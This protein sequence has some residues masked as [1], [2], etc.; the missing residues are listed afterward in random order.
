MKHLLLLFFGIVISPLFSQKNIANQ[1]HVWGSYTGL[2]LLSPKV[3]WLTE[4]QARSANGIQQ[5]QQNL[6]RTGIEY[7]INSKISCMLGYAWVRTYP[8]GEQPVLH[9][10]DEQRI[11]EQITLKSNLDRVDI[12]HRYRLEQRWLDQYYL[13]VSGQ[14]YEGVVGFRNRIRYRVM[15]T[16]PLSKP[17]LSDNTLFL[18]VNNEVFLGF[19][20]GIAKNPLDQN[21]FITALGWRFNKQTNLQLG[22]LNQFIIKG[23]GLDMERNHTLWMGLT[24]NVDFSQKGQP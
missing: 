10:F 14:V 9:S 7:A 19:G 5:W 8:Y 17:S 3:A 24:Y 22:Y 11:F 18:N 2:H 1:R 16:L 20:K 13:D 4:Y 6:V 15:L 21:R 23:N 12:Q